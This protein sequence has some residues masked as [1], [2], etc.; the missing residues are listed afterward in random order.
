MMKS[1]ALPQG[2]RAKWFWWRRWV[3][4]RTSWP[5]FLGKCLLSLVI[6]GALWG[7]VS[8]RYSI[9][10][11]AGQPCMRG[12]VYLIKRGKPEFKHGDIIEFRTDNRQVPY[13]PGSKFIKLVR[14]VPG[15]R[16]RIDASGKVQITGKN[17]HFESALEPRVIKLLH[18][19]YRDLAGQ[20]A[21]PSGSYFVM[22]TLPDSYDSRYWG[23]VKSDQVVGKGLA[24]FGQ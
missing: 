21:I 8:A 15:D 13:P 19:R 7:W 6:M 1:R 10:I 22:G 9:G 20:Y 2:Y 14:G 24:V 11:A 23:L 18:K 4:T 12:L 17:Y 16:V 3:H 5:L